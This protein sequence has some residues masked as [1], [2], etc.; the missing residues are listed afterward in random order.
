MEITK[1]HCSSQFN[2]SWISPCLCLPPS[3]CQL[4]LAS[5]TLTTMTA[6]GLRSCIA[7]GLAA[8]KFLVLLVLCFIFAFLTLLGLVWCT[9][10]GGFPA[11]GTDYNVVFIIAGLA[12]LVFACAL[13][14][15]CGFRNR[16]AVI[17]YLIILIVLSAL[18]ALIVHFAHS[19]HGL[20]ADYQAWVSTW[21]IACAASVH[22]MIQVYWLRR[23]PCILLPPVTSSASGQPTNDNAE[24]VELPREGMV[25]SAIMRSSISLG[26]LLLSSPIV[27][28]SMGFPPKTEQLFSFIAL[29]V[30]AVV[31]A[32][33]FVVDPPSAP[34]AM[35]SS[36]YEVRN[37]QLSCRFGDCNLVVSI[38]RFAMSWRG[39]H[40]IVCAN[41]LVNAGFFGYQAYIFSDGPYRFYRQGPELVAFMLSA[42]TL[43][44]VVSAH[45]IWVD[46]SV[47][48]V[49]RC[50]FDR[51]FRTSA[52]LK[53]LM[54]FLKALLLRSQ[55]C[56]D[57]F[58][59]PDPAGIVSNVTD[60]PFRVCLSHT[61]GQCCEGQVKNLTCSSCG[62]TCGS[63]DCTLYRVEQIAKRC[64]GSLCGNYCY[65]GLHQKQLQ[66]VVSMLLLSL[67]T[68]G[69]LLSLTYSDI[70]E[71]FQARRLHR[72]VRSPVALVYGYAVI[73]LLPQLSCLSLLLTIIFAKRADVLTVP[74]CTA[75]VLAETMS[76]FTAFEGARCL[77]SCRSRARFAHSPTPDALRGSL[78]DCAAA[79]GCRIFL[80]VTILGE[81]GLRAFAAFQV[82]IGV[83]LIAA[84]T[85]LAFASLSST[86]GT[87]SAP[88]PSEESLASVSPLLVSFRPIHPSAN[89]PGTA[90]IQ[91]SV[92]FSVAEGDLLHGADIPPQHP[93]SL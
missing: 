22:A 4:P 87:S 46:S 93:S 73:V 50:R 53:L 20:L 72:I 89:P 65:L 68:L 1:H 26:S 67:L 69:T 81:A 2:S 44:V 79:N 49:E 54:F 77:D 62:F 80:A 18:G 86:I 10:G 36:Q 19:G 56:Q 60:S 23:E 17:V 75:F 6:C 43:T 55:F 78:L 24:L 25:R 29:T 84:V 38:A 41:G 3:F 42:S 14:R 61:N 47:S 40:W 58:L 5:L 85:K 15:V 48:G 37:L 34:P 45:A 39:K 31:A 57:I 11:P 74:L 63:G 7:V 27:F 30:C 59:Y 35:S 52:W 92:G 76:K 64:D 88:T 21:V 51:T 8:F 90:P 71:L 66:T 32:S 13:S 91:Q 83:A 16:I 33:A 82:A 70:R 9:M 28:S 12:S